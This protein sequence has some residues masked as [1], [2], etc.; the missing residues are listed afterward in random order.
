MKTYL[1]LLSLLFSFCLQAQDS[2]DVDNNAGPGKGHM[3]KGFSAG[4]LTGAYFANKYSAALYNGYG[5][6]VS[7]KQNNFENSL[8]NQQV[9]YI[10][11]GKGPYPATDR[12]AQAL[13]VDHN[14]WNFSESDMPA[15]VHYNIAFIAGLQARYAFNENSAI[16]AAANTMRVGTNADFTITTF[17]AG[18]GNSPT[19]YLRT[20]SLVGSEQRTLLQIGYQN[21]GGDNDSRVN[22][23]WELG[24][25][26]ALTKVMKNQANIN[27]LIID[28][29]STYY[30]QNGYSYYQ[31]NNYAAFKAKYLQGIGYGLFGGLGLNVSLS[32]QWII[33]LIYNPA[34]DKVNM[35]E[36][37]KFTLQHTAGLR[38]YYCF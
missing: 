6:D 1:V 32:P 17:T 29:T 18:V 7:G 15:N 16:I 4:F 21:V 37:P 24:F 33:Q 34:L 19:P 22:F 25:D 23:L 2:L 11:G 38:G 31:N 35:G 10:N 20:F 5:L 26:L 12:V 3:R 36:A 9:N 30:F 8:M 13:N 27:G 14:S 28:L